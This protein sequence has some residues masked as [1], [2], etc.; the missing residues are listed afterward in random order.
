MKAIVLRELGEPENLRL[1][2][3]ADPQPEANEVVI[4]LKA[5]ALN[6][7]DIF[8]RRGL[9]AGIKLPI[10]L[11]SDGAGEV[12]AAGAEVDRSLVGKAVVINPSLDWGEDERAQGSAFRILGLPDDGT[13]AQLIK[14]PAGNIYAKPVALSFE[15]AA[16]IPLAGLTAYRAVVTRAQVQA[17]ETVL[18]TGIGGGVSS[19]A[20]QIARHLGARVLVTSGSDAKLAR[21]RGLGAEGG[22]NYRTGNWVKE[23]AMLAGDKGVDVIVDSVGGET[24]AQALEVIK[25]GGRIVSYGA[26]TGAAKQIEV[27]RIFWKQVNILGSTMGTPREFGAMLGL[28]GNSALRP[29]VDQVFPL[30]EAP[31]AHRRMEEAGQF[32]KIVLRI[33]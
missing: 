26:T 4:R 29:V 11:G 8:I 2:E 24:F 32:G 20:L 9:Y 27:R 21:A 15:E 30:A 1:E 3:V 14:V 12:V 17:G 19:F 28:Y 23:V 13:Y 5:A 16:A 6:H 25:P 31:A 33:A 18:V 7:R 10:I 22:A